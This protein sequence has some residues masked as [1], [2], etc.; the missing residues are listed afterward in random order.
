MPGLH[1]CSSK[2]R[3]GNEQTLSL[4]ANSDHAPCTVQGCHGQ[5]T[6]SSRPREGRSLYG[7]VSA[8][9][10]C[11]GHSKH[12]PSTVQGCKGSSSREGGSLYRVA[13]A[14]PEQIW[15]GSLGTRCFSCPAGSQYEATELP[16]SRTLICAAEGSISMSGSREPTLGGSRCGTVPASSPTVCCLQG[17]SQG[18]DARLSRSRTHPNRAGGVW[19]Q[20]RLRC[21]YPLSGSPE[22]LGWEAAAEQRH[23]V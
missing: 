12:A 7:V 4:R 22:Q 23:L 9:P 16:E 15:Q 14:T 21:V 5:H 20:P 17:Q 1:T 11:R 2:S 8:D 19:K 13:S 3:K 10:Q 18:P 6:C